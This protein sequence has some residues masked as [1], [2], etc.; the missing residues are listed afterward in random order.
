MNM[1]DKILKEYAEL[2]SDVDKKCDEV[3]DKVPNIPCKNKCFECCKQLFP[4]SFVEAFYIS[5]GFKKPDRETRRQMQRAAKKIADKISAQNPAQF[6]KRKI[7]RTEAINTHAEFAHFLQKDTHICPTLNKKNSAS[8]C[9]LYAFRNL[10]CRVAGFS[11]DSSSNEIVACERFK[12]L[13]H[14][15]PHLLPFNYKYSEKMRLDRALLSEMTAGAFTPNII[16]L[17]TMCGPIL[18]DYSSTDWL[19]YFTKK[20]IPTKSKEDE[21]W[22]VIDS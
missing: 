14:I 8:P 4:L 12:S 13:S 17:T 3:S 21:Y 2:L 11:F 6:E 5:E 10:D 15:I 9:E 1:R 22:V 20:G 7:S 16:Y 18:K 19:D